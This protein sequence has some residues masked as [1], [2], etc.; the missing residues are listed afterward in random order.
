MI[1]MYFFFSLQSTLII[2][3][4]VSADFLDSQINRF[5]NS[6]EK[7]IYSQI[8]LIKLGNSSDTTEFYFSQILSL[9][10]FDF[11]QSIDC[12]SLKIPVKESFLIFIK[13]IESQEIKLFPIK[14]YEN[15]SKILGITFISQNEYLT[16]DSNLNLQNEIKK[17]YIKD[18]ENY[19]MVLNNHKRYK[20]TSSFYMQLS[21][22][23][24]T[25]SNCIT[26][27]VREFT[28]YNQFERQD[29]AQV[30]L[31]LYNYL[32]VFLLQVSN[33]FKTLCQ[34]NDFMLAIIKLM[35]Q[36]NFDQEI[37]LCKIYFNPNNITIANSNPSCSSTSLFLYNYLNWQNYCLKNFSSTAG[38]LGA[39]LSKELLLS[40]ISIS[41]FISKLS[42]KGYMPVSTSYTTISS[43]IE[44]YIIAEVKTANSYY[45]A[46]FLYSKCKLGG[47]EI[48]LDI[49][50]Q[51]IKINAIAPVIYRKLYIIGYY[52]FYF[53]YYPVYYPASELICPPSSFSEKINLYYYLNSKILT[54]SS[55][56]E[57]RSFDLQSSYCSVLFSNG[58]FE[59]RPKCDDSNCEVCLN[60]SNNCTECVTGYRV[61]A[62]KCNVCSINCY[63]CLNQDKCLLCN[64]EFYVNEN[65]GLCE[66]CGSKCLSCTNNQCTNCQSGTCPSSFNNSCII[67]HSCYYCVNET[68]CQTCSA[69]NS[70]MGLTGCVCKS[71]FYLDSSGNCSYCSSEC[72]TC[73]NDQ[74]CLSCKYNNSMIGSDQKCI[75]SNGYYLKDETLSSDNSCVK[76]PIGCKE[77]TNSSNCLN[78]SSEN[79]TLD[80]GLCI[81]NIGFYNSTTGCTVC[82]DYCMKCNSSNSCIE[83]KSKFTIPSAST[84]KCIKGY[85]IDTELTPPDFCSACSPECQSCINWDFCVECVSSNTLVN[86]GKCQ[87]IDGYYNIS[88]MNASN[89]CLKCSNKCETCK[90]EF[91][92]LSCLSINSLPIDGNCVCKEGFYNE[93]Q[94]ITADS[95]KPCN[96]D[97]GKCISLDYCLICILENS[98]QV[99]GTCK[100]KKGFYKN[101]GLCSKCNENCLVCESFDLC[102]NCSAINTFGPQCEICDESCMTCSNSSIFDCL[103]CNNSSLLEGVC[104]ETC[105]L[106]YISNN[107]T[108]ELVQNPIFKVTFESVGNKFYDI[109]H[110]YTGQV[111]Y[112]N[113]IPKPNLEYSG[114]FN[115]FKRGAYFSGDSLISFSFNKTNFLSHKF[116]FAIW[117]YAM[118]SSGTIFYL[119][120]NWNLL[121]ITTSKW[122]NLQLKFEQLTVKFEFQVENITQE[123]ESNHKFQMKIWN[124]VVVEIESVHT[125]LISLILND[126]R[127]NFLFDSERFRDSSCSNLMIGSNLIEQFNGFMY[128][129]EVYTSY[130]NFSFLSSLTT[131]ECNGCELCPY[132]GICIPTCE[133]MQYYN[134]NLFVCDECPKE[135]K[136]GCKNSSTCDLCLDNNCV[137]CSSFQPIS[138]VECK[139][140]YEVKNF[141]CQKCLSSQFYEESSKSCKACPSLCKTCSSEINCFTCEE[142]SS[143]INKTCKCNSGYSFQT[144]CL[145]NTFTAKSW[146]SNENIFNIIFSEPLSIILDESN[147]KITINN[148]QAEFSLHKYDNQNY[149]LTLKSNDYT[150]GSV[151][152]VQIISVI[153][154]ESNS[155]LISTSFS[156]ELR[157]TKSQ[158]DA[159]ELES[160]IKNSQELAST[161]TIAGASIALGLGLMNFDLTSIFDFLNTAEMFYSVY[162]FNIDLNPI[163]S[164]FLLGLRIQK[165]I[166]NV[167][168]YV[169]KIPNDHDLPSKFHKFGY[170]KSISLINIGIQVT[171]LGIITISWT[172]VYLLNKIQG[173]QKYLNS[174]YDHLTFSVFLRFWLQTF[175]EI[176]I[177]SSVS[178]MYQYLN[179]KLNIIETIISSIILVNDK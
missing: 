50:L 118:K 148:K 33:H 40:S 147:L 102:L 126:I 3:Q 138:C 135:C 176:L 124:H 158:S 144:S 149:Y 21:D 134:E 43:Q 76:C 14:C 132:T 71:G 166:P 35:S 20:R 46:N 23:Y 15:E 89:S 97:C 18:R 133:V 116:A 27:A 162:L 19:K 146:L 165:S 74:N 56:T 30:A 36:T 142:N 115:S 67:N 68:A 29:Y 178:I 117:I 152:I 113:I 94:L 109:I 129:F 9:N 37:L 155:L 34:L 169:I 84:C 16:I 13:S 140:S 44:S 32:V 82:P 103:T 52:Y 77:C 41:S 104:F 111:I 125:L 25:K 122:I 8:V 153:T 100:C 53:I 175:L 156:A 154:S 63:L 167:L 127:Q 114:I 54:T 48:I 137:S 2:F 168:N 139:E 95:C 93:T 128:L 86:N 10:D 90:S 78:C 7:S 1:S 57:Y 92:C 174:I 64:D 49:E 79:S 28:K 88:L 106:G 161:G 26:C 38:G 42:E 107:E 141:L 136:V 4:L 11:N 159:K 51:F 101:N 98:Y 73:E 31:D 75:C 130:T 60:A 119:G 131:N 58:I 65:T 112:P 105:P 179:H 177:V 80:K 69:S 110:N 55:I 62:G 72:Q 87:C 173:I 121:N 108:C 157:I 163:L 22:L 39:S 6:S 81:C 172:V 59:L 170:K 83:C 47:T 99:N 151:L 85:G 91:Y 17:I 45:M 12:S 70:I 61:E 164:E 143:L 120:E 145:R 24:L 66:K 160:K 171:T 150:D 5:L 96:S 123:V